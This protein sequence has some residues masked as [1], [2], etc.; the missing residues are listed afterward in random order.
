MTRFVVGIAVGV[1]ATYTLS[2]LT[3]IALVAATR[4]RRPV[5]AAAPPLDSGSGREANR[6]LGASRPAAHPSFTVWTA[7]DL[8][9]LTWLEDNTE[10]QYA[11]LW[12]RNVRDDCPPHGIQRPE[13]DK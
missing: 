12:R 5:P 10:W 1:A 2:T 9:A 6:P 13:L 3:L 8:A 11:H 4:R 7:D